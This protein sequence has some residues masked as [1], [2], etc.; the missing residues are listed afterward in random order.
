MIK[1]KKMFYMAR[2]VFVEHM[3]YIEAQWFDIIGTIV[4]VFL[5]Y[6]IWQIVFKN[7]DSISGYTLK[8]MTTYIILSRVLSSQ[9]SDGI[10]ETFAEWIYSGRIGTEL[11]RPVSI[12]TILWTRR[13]GEVAFS[14]IFKALPTLVIAFFI[15]GGTTPL[16]IMYL[17]LF[18]VSILI[19]IGIMFMIEM[20]FGMLCCYTLTHFA[21]SFT[22]TAIIEFLGG[23]IIPLFLFPPI[24]GNVLSILPFAGMI[25]LPINFYLGKISYFE[26]IRSIF[27]E[28]IWIAVF[29]IINKLL[30][31]HVIKRVVVQGG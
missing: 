13:I 2:I 21:L 31:N 7:H 30:F 14:T 10:N 6:V 17:A 11:T 20:L 22:K 4:S 24:L 12:F 15:L 23:G 25:Y 9:F 19:S 5:Y 3:S 1:I 26:G 27:I 29:A 18:V 16:N 8:Q 28:V